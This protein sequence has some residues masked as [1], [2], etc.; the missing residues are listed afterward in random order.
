MKLSRR[1]IIVNLGVESSS[2]EN[3]TFFSFNEFK[4]E[5]YLIFPGTK[6]SFYVEP[7]FDKS[8]GVESTK[9]V[10]IEVIY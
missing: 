1:F 2:Y 7:T 3:D 5:E 10:E 9:A 6:V 4:D 8:K